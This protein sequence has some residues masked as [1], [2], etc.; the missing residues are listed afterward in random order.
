MAEALRRRRRV[1][2]GG[3]AGLAKAAAAMFDQPVE[4]AAH[5]QHVDRILDISH[6]MLPRYVETR[7]TGVI[8]KIA[9]IDAASPLSNRT[10]WGLEDPERTFIALSEPGENSDEREAFTVSSATLRTAVEKLGA[11]GVSACISV[12]GGNPPGIHNTQDPAV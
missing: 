9:P 12:G 1:S 6:D 7:N 5:Q 2:Q 3:A 11:E 8:H 4:Y 10:L